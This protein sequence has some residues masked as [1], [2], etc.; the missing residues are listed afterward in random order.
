MAGSADREQMENKEFQRFSA[1]VSSR[2]LSMAPMMDWTGRH[3]RYFHW[4]LSRHALL[5]TEMVTTGALIHGD[6]AR[7]LRF[8]AEE[9]LVALQLGGSEPADLGPVQQA[10]PAM[11]L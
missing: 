5:H 6:V 4:L 7:H 9:H 11:G 2:R 3:C 1:Q 10:G 8:N